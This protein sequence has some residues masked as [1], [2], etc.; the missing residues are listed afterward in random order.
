MKKYSIPE[1][2]Q[3]LE[4]DNSYDY[5]VFGKRTESFIAWASTQ[6]F[7]DKTLADM[8]V[9]YEKIN[10]RFPSKNLRE[11]V[12]KKYN[13]TCQ[14]C[15]SKD[16]LH[17]DHIIPYSKGGWTKEDNLTVLCSKCNY[18]KKDKI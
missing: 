16:N 7:T 13:S 8:A 2:T 6:D 5:Y 4:N 1:I 17:I 3:M 15:G 12:L 9:Y 11:I 10:P 14:E 18:K